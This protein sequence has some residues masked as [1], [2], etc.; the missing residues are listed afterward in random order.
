MRL[1]KQLF[2][3]TLILSFTLSGPVQAVTAS[4]INQDHEPVKTSMKL[5]NEGRSDLQELITRVDS[6]GDTSSN[7][8]S[9]SEEPETTTPAEPASSEDKAPAEKPNDTIK[10]DD[11][12]KAKSKVKADIGP[13]AITTGTNG[14]SN[15]EFDSDT[16]LLTFGAG[17]LSEQIDNNLSAAGI[18]NTAVKKIK[19]DGQVI[20]PTAVTY[21]FA[22]LGQL[23]ECI[24]LNH[25]DTSAVTSMKGWF[26]NSKGLT[27]PDLSSFNTSNVTNM[28]FM[29]YETGATSLDLSNWNVDKVTTFEHM[30]YNASS[31]TT[32]N[33]SDWGTNRT[34][35]GANVSMYFMFYGTS[36][37]TT[38][39]LTDFKTTRVT[40]MRHMFQG[41]GLTSLDLSDWDVTRVVSFAEMFYNAKLT[42]LNLST[43]GTNRTAT[44]VNM[45]YM[46]YGTSALTTLNL[47]DFKT[48]R[49]TYMNGMFSN[50]GLTS[51]DLSSWDVTKVTT[52]DRMF[53]SAT[54]LTSL[55]LSTWGTNRTAT[56]VNMGYMFYGTSAL[57]TLNLTDFKT[58]RVTDMRYMFYGTG[59]TSLDLSSWDV[60]KVT[61]FAYMFYAAKLASLNLSTWGT[62][63]TAT[64]V[65]MNNMFYGTS[66][67]TTLT[68]TDFKTTN[69]TDMSY[70]FS[71]TGLTSLDL[72]SWDVTQ[73]T[74]FNYMFQGAQTLRTL[75]LANWDTASLTS[76]TNI[77]MFSG[78]SKLWQITLGEKIK[79]AG[80][81]GFANAPA[82]NTKFTDNGQ[83]YMVT[84]PSWQAVGS[85]TVHRPTG[86]LVTTTQMYADRTAPITYVWAQAP[87]FDSLPIV[88]F[89]TLS[90]SDFANEDGYV[91]SSGQTVSLINLA[92]AER[93]SISVEQT[94]DWHADGE[95]ATISRNTLSVALN[96]QSGVF[97]EGTSSTSE[98]EV[99][100]QDD[101]G[102]FGLYFDKSTTIPQSLLNKTLK[103]ELTWTLNIIPDV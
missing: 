76:N 83:N 68:L 16:G 55:N 64:N 6:Q 93:Y 36:V 46:F 102:H 101:G 33:L 19:F 23:N 43:W 12:T 24:D 13:Q 90:A 62:N 25:F 1:K 38:L 67:L 88:N 100:F 89:G 54:Q 3:T 99:T 86:D 98:K 53:Q 52:F 2:L 15:W 32:L 84:T 28:S 103:S 26:Y 74:T 21:L 63:R 78:T 72:S 35:T 56:G 31:L 51:L 80:N 59:L 71:A 29:F 79:F 50:T 81:P 61:T 4:E 42:N 14:T 48:T 20:A 69:V 39:N 18:V 30:F 92:N 70:M 75:N 66:A 8:A 34:T 7:E 45:N 49:V 95:S 97:W 44:N 57:T 41:T 73:V 17:Q 65:N 82:A 96:T 85:G 91:S 5:P 60:T 87:T 37:L 77:N 47:T 58:T 40:D 22:N 9:E 10:T 27:N 11:N 94:D